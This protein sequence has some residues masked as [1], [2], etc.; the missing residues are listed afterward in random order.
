MLYNIII[1]I[2]ITATMLDAT[3]TL[4]LLDINLKFF[5][6]ALFDVFD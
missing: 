4:N 1:I 5:A 3:K 2:I 6:F